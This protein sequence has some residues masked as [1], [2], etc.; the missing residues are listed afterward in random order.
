MFYQPSNRRRISIHAPARGASTPCAN[1]VASYIY[2]NSRPCERGFRNVHES[3]T[4]R[5]YFNSRPCERGFNVWN[6]FGDWIAI[7]IHA[8]ARGASVASDTKVPY[9]LLFQFTP[10]REGLHQGF[11]KQN[12]TM[13]ISIHAPARGA[14]QLRVCF[15]YC[16]NHFNSRPCERGF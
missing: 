11:A 6:I 5:C 12:Y 13:L 16:L 4:C 9:S 10:L 2:F 8:P 14:S 7:S 15:C 1:A 3:I